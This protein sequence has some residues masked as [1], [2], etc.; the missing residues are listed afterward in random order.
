M[1][2]LLNCLPSLR[3]SVDIPFDFNEEFALEC[4]G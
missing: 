4:L 1:A 2:V 3:R